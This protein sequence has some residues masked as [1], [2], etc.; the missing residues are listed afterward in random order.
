MFIFSDFFLV[1]SLVEVSEM[2]QYIVTRAIM[3]LTW[4]DRYLRWNASEFQVGDTDLITC[5]GIIYFA[6][7]LY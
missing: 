5:F 7:R 1:S 6:F 4:E 3:Y 2:D